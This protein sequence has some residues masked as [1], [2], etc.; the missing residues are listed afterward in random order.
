MHLRTV[1]PDAL[2]EI[3]PR[4]LPWIA[5]ACRRGTGDQTPAD[6]RLICRRGEGALILICCEDGEPVAAG[7]TQVRDHRDGARTCWV[8]AV[9]GAGA[10]SWLDTLG[11]IEANAARIGCEAVEFVGRPGW[12]RLLPDYEA[13]TSYVRRLGPAAVSQPGL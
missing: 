7:V 3:W 1:A 6:L 5:D 11:V 8:L 9:G 2:T 10:R 13:R 12:A 4:V